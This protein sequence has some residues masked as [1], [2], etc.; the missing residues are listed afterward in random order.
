MSVFDELGDGVFRRRYESLDLNVGVVLGEDGVLL[1]D[2]RSTTA[3]GAE[4]EREVRLLTT[5]PVR[6]VVNTH[7]HWDHTF[8]NSVF[9]E[10]EV[11][12]HERCA[13]TL[14]ERPDEMREG[15]AKWF[16]DR[17]EEFDAV[18]IVPPSKTLV[19]SASLAIGREILLGFHG[20]GHT[21][22]D[23]IVDVADAQVCFA[24]DLVEEGAPPSFGDSYP[25]SW[26][27]TLRL[28]SDSMSA[29]VVPGHGDV[30]DKTF[31]AG[32]HA[33][34]VAVAEL[35]SQCIGESLTV[36]EAVAAGPYP[37]SVMRS[38]IG[39]AIEVS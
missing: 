19:N 18:E 36:D 11:W 13:E 7:W 4:L 20:L 5:K 31:V 24:G 3:E 10:A 21:D 9:R 22:S 6:W 33:E 28:A 32:Q 25:L 15:A 1:V 23:L 14:R 35:A 2:T 12:G 29:T 34:L 27:L 16:P 37:E 38:A 17:R 8:G 30:V 39:R 26:P